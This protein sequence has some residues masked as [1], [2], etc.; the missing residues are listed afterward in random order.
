MSAASEARL[1]RAPIAGR[2]PYDCTV[3]SIVAAVLGLTLASGPMPFAVRVAP[4]EDEYSARLE[5]VM[6]HAQRA[7][8]LH[9]ASQYDEEIEELKTAISLF[10]TDPE[11]VDRLRFAAIR[12]QLALAYLSSYRQ[13]GDAAK[14]EVA[15]EELQKILG[16]WSESPPELEAQIA[17][18]RSE[19]ETL[20]AEIDALLAEEQAAADAAA[21]DEERREQ[22]RRAAEVERE[23]QR[24][25]QSQKDAARADRSVGRGL[26]AG[27]SVLVGVG[28]ASGVLIGIGFNNARKNAELY[29]QDGHAEDEYETYEQKFRNGNALG[30]AGSVVAGT[31][32]TA[33]V[34]LIVVGA[35]ARRRAGNEMAVVPQFGRDRVGA[36]VSFRF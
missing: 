31:F 36:S 3:P 7:R 11:P 26:I 14:L 4:A 30:I 25:E 6:E 12:Q 10:P 15:R 2:N 22:E 33:G 23:Q 34:A 32:I 27:G 16:E 8:N 24:A 5:N 18:R 17:E 29:G 21:A 20:L 13:A 35:R 19:A 28:A 9:E 1:Y